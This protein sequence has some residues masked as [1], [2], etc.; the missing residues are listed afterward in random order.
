M[1]AKAFQACSIGPAQESIQSKD[2]KWKIDAFYLDSSGRSIVSLP[3][4]LKF[5]TVDDLDAFL[6]SNCI[7]P[8][9]ENSPVILGDDKEENEE[10]ETSTF[11]R[12]IAVD[13]RVTLTVGNAHAALARVEGVTIV[14]TTVENDCCSILLSTEVV[15]RVSR[16]DDGRNTGDVK[17]TLE[18]TASLTEETKSKEADDALSALNL[19]QSFNRADQ[20]IQ[21]SPVTRLPPFTVQVVLTHALSIGIRSIPGPEMGQTF[22]ALHMKHSNTHSQPVTIKSIELHPGVSVMRDPDSPMDHQHTITAD[23]SKIAKWSFSNSDPSLPLVIKPNEAY[24]SVLTV[25]AKEDML[26]RQCACPLSITAF[27]HGRHEIVAAVDA[28]FHTAR[29]AA[30]PSD[31]LGVQMHIETDT[32]RVGAPLSL[33]LEVSNLSFETRQLMLMI[34]RESNLNKWAIVSDVQGQKFGISGPEEGQDLLAVDAALVLG[35][36]KGNSSTKATLRLIPLRPGAL[37]IPNFRF[38]DHRSGKRYYCA[39]KLQAVAS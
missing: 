36:L 16:T 25:F 18:M 14:S 27:V 38:V 9:P 20:Q 5:A 26:A 6:A 4:R 12:T 37:S 19:L 13:A 2:G 17:A 22:L 8:E 15:V 32:V 21:P 10:S 35:E 28:V 7:H 1:L 31:G 29:S 33:A 23:M 3:L 11:E 30:E 39:H 34:D 24:S